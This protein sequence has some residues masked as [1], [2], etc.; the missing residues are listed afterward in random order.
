MPS[1][2]TRLSLAMPEH[3]R[4]LVVI[5]ILA[6]VVFFFARRPASALVPPATF[7]RWR[8]V[9]L[10]LTL[11][12]FL[13]PSFWGYATIASIVLLLTARQE[14]FRPGLFLFLLFLIP[15]ATVDIP[16]FGL[17]N[18][19]FSLSYPRLLALVLLLPA[20]FT[21]RWRTGTPTFGKYWPDKLLIVYL[22]LA[23][24]LQLRETT[25]TDTLRQA[26]YFFIDVVLPYYVMSRWLRDLSMFKAALFGYTLAGLLL[27]I[28][29][30]F[31]M[32]RHWLLYSSLV[33]ALGLEWGYGGYLG[34]ADWIRAS[35]ST[36]Q[37]IALGYAI[38]V[39]IGFYLFLQRY[40]QSRWQRRLSGGLLVAGM[41]ASLS[42]GPWVG[43]TALFVAYIG[44]GRN[45]L[46]RL[47]L[48]VI[49]GLLAL[50]LLAVLPGGEKV[51]NLLPFIGKTEVE[52]IDY[53]QRLIDNATVVIKRNPW[54]GSVNYL[55][56]PEMQSMMQGQKIIDVVNT[57]LR[58]ALNYGLVGL[59]LFVGFFVLVL[60]NIRNAYRKIANP[61]DEIRV[62]GR[63]L[64]ATLIGILITIFTV[65]S[66]TIIPIVYWSVAGLGVA[67]AQMVRDH[68]AAQT[69]SRAAVA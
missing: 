69:D 11:T 65:S 10:T 17:I 39:A 4:A 33:S 63:A 26:F 40:L 9:W 18:Y 14:Q 20:A 31:E 3:L 56:T 66:I 51:I 6:S 55:N 15:A 38:M 37:A 53:R 64:F 29:G 30:V 49:A 25:F 35:A 19:L 46:R 7:A 2:Q 24:L 62:L 52:N 13:L 12:A 47:T 67:Y 34:R 36:G 23:T 28:I 22:L 61:E 59:G 54:F 45:A 27:A 58:V 16:G 43:A 42:R 57:Y 44:T 21:L 60:F 41:V 48:L 68:L 8:N 50:P 5:L 32:S 1:L